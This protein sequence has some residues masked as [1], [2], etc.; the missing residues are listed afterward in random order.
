M[1]VS[2]NRRRASLETT[3]RLLS[4]LIN[5]GLVPAIV[6]HEAERSWLNIQA[7]HHRSL[8]DVQVEL[9]VPLRKGAFVGLTPDE[10]DNNISRVNFIK[11]K[12]LDQPIRIRG[13]DDG[14]EN[15]V[16]QSDPCTIFDIIRQGIA[17][18]VVQPAMR[19]RIMGQLK[20][21]VDMQGLY[22]FCNS[23]K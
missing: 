13:A 4:H 21:S 18:L 15:S 8:K 1:T 23:T 2:P 5:E 22:I 11:P 9:L 10:K 16:E 17:N 12:D 6:S 14:K 19:D 3:K 20:N 7:S